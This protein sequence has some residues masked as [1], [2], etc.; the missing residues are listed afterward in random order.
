MKIRNRPHSPPLRAELRILFIIVE[1][2]FCPSLMQDFRSFL[3]N[4]P[5]L[6]VSIFD[7][8]NGWLS[9]TKYYLKRLIVR[10][11]CEQI[12]WQIAA[13][14]KRPWKLTITSNN[15]FCQF[16]DFPDRFPKLSVS[17]MITMFIILCYSNL[18]KINHFKPIE[19]ILKFG[20][21]FIS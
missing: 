5:A 1:N 4:F 8:I 13:A 19:P 20:I 7:E 15:I 9:R 6:F 21:K 2:C 11:L 3:S 18:N 16:Y 14:E 10:V 12:L 17:K